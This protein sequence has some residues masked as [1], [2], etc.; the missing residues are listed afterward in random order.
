MF[1][2]NSATKSWCHFEWRHTLLAIAVT[3]TR[4]LKQLLK[5]KLTR[6]FTLC[7]NLIVIV[8]RYL[9]SF[10]N[11]L[12]HWVQESIH[13]NYFQPHSTLRWNLGIFIS[14]LMSRD[15]LLANQ[16]AWIVNVC[17]KKKSF[18]NIRSWPHLLNNHFQSHKISSQSVY[19]AFNFTAI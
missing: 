15:C 2:W 12:Q 16:K 14:W 6:K 13:L 5:S 19:L 8:I 18:Y 9:E 11:F 10:D 4:T 3:L 1:A 17:W 7:C